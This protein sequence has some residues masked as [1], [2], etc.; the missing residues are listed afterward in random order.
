[1]LGFGIASDLWKDSELRDLVGDLVNKTLK[2]DVDILRNN[3]ELSYRLMRC[4]LKSSLNLG[5][6]RDE[7][8]AQ[9]TAVLK[10]LIQVNV[11]YYSTLV[12]LNLTFTERLLSTVKA[13]HDQ[14]PEPSPPTP[15]TAE[16]LTMKLAANLGE[17][18]RMP[19][20]IE[21][22]RSK[23]M[24]V[25]FHLTAFRR[26]DEAQSVTAKAMFEPHAVELQPREE[27]QIFLVLPVT[28][29]FEPGHHY[30][31]L[32][33]AAGMDAMQIQVD[34]EVRQASPQPSSSGS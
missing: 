19:F 23:A 4:G 28:D 9:T 30:R 7:D 3:A 31:A 14:A 6:N 16:P 5:R 13:P 33:S 10:D 24:R 8:T 11:G 15:A 1:M 17:W 2:A 27:A 18:L 22:N 29:P 32:L 34:L 21:N 26:S 20:R 12:D 25:T